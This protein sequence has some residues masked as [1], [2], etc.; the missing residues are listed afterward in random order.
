MLNSLRA[1]IAWVKTQARR[2]SPSGAAL[3]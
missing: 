3:R 1:V 2:Q